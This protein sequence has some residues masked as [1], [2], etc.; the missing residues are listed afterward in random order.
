MGLLERIQENQKSKAE[1][2]NRKLVILQRM[3]IKALAKMYDDY[4]DM[5]DQ[6]SKYI[7]P[8]SI[9]DFATSLIGGMDSRQKLIALLAD[10]LTL[11]LI[12]QQAKAAG[13]AVKDIVGDE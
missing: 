9:A 1:R 13:V 8:G 2:R 6:K 11:E 7:E 5:G 12:V 4:V 3:P 10:S